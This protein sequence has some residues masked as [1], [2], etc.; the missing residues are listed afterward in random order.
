MSR[1]LGLGLPLRQVSGALPSPAGRALA[2]WFLLRLGLVTPER[3]GAFQVSARSTRGP[4]SYLHC[5]NLVRLLGVN[6]THGW[7]A[8]QDGVRLEI[9]TPSLVHAD[10]PA[11]RGARRAGPGSHRCVCSWDLWFAPCPAVSIL[12]ATPGLLSSLLC[13]RLLCGQERGFPALHALDWSGLAFQNP[14]KAL[15]MKT[16]SS[17]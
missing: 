8:P 14:F 17:A 3:S 4:L 9:R 6:L 12:G 11:V 7:T 2:G 13:F 10:P 1:G 16:S 5:E 15:T